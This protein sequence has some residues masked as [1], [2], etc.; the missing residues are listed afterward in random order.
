MATLINVGGTSRSGSTMLHL[1]LGNA[2]DTFSCGEVMNW[3]RPVKTNQFKI[4][5]PCGEDP[6]PIWQ[7][8]DPATKARQ[9]HVAAFKKLEINYLIDSSKELSW[10]IDARR[11]AVIKD[12]EIFN[13]FVWKNPLDLAYSFW[14]RG[15]D[16]MFWRSQFV[17]YYSRVIQVGLP[18]L[19][20][21]YNDLVR[22]PQQKVMEICTTL[23]MPYFEGKERF[24]EKQSHHLFGSLGVRRQVEHGNSVIKPKDDFPPDF[25]AHVDFLK[26]QIAADSEVQSIIKFLHRADISSIT[27]KDSYD[28]KFLPRRPYPIWYYKQRA[29][30]FFHKRFPKK[31]NPEGREDVATI[32]LRK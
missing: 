18:V 9:F 27:S 32:P 15:Q 11:W 20:V 5:C 3:Y 28:Q 29:K 13:I 16:R 26:N 6:C 22:N 7:K 10:I 30:R 12:L 31:F 14:K 17:K 19:A 23:G 2:E 4:R 25:E 21:N 1:I 8:L 24:W